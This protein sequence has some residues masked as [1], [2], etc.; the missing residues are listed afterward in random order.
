[1][2]GKDPSLLAWSRAYRLENGRPL[3]FEAFP[4]QLEIYESAFADRDLPTVDVM[5]SAQVGVSA[6]G[7]S[8]ALY[9]ADIW[10]ANVLYVFPTA[11]DV[12]DFS[13]TRVKPAI[14]ASAYLRSRVSSTDN[15]GLRRVGEA[16]I[17]FRGSRSESK[18]LSIAVD[19]VVF[20]EFDWLDKTNVPKFRRRLNAPTSMKLERRFSNPSFPED[21]IHAE[22]LRSDQRTWLVRCPACLNEAPISWDGGDGDHYVDRE[23]KIRACGRCKKLLGSEAV[24]AGRWVAARADAAPRAYHMSR[25]IVPGENI[26]ELVANHAKTDETSKQAFYN[27]DLGVPYSPKGGSLP[28]DLIL[29]CRRRYTC[30]DSYVGPEWVT[31]GVDVG[32]VLHVRISRHLENGQV[33]PLYIDTVGDFTD[34][35]QLMDRYQVRFCVVDERPEERKAREFMEAFAGRVMLLRWSGDEQRD[36]IA[37]DDDR[38]LIVARRTGACDRLVAQVG[39]QVRL[40]PEHL[41]DGYVSQMGAPHRVT[42]TNRRGQKVARYVSE[43]ADHFF[44][45]EMHDMIAREVRSGN[46]IDIAGDPG[47]NI[48]ERAHRRRVEGRWG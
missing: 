40:L 7:V 44:F 21:G 15:K 30:P 10:G 8:L 17:Y 32:A 31:A 45:A 47:E 36:Q 12:H 41:P 23:R 35:A 2:S 42:E 20:D 28:R 6:A 18:A 25:L 48:L 33:A 22:W 9:A 24:A 16:F 14:E 26:G 43:R 46:P 13:D 3:D 37:T 1:M 38:G 29:A 34:L 19:L 5:K 27:L 39:A 11:D 4:M